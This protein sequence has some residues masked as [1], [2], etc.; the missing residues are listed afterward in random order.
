MRLPEVVHGCASCQLYYHPVIGCP[1]LS[2]GYQPLTI[3]SCSILPMRV[4]NSKFENALWSQDFPTL[5]K[6]PA[7]ELRPTRD[8]DQILINLETYVLLKFSFGT[9]SKI[10]AWLNENSRHLMVGA[11][12]DTQFKGFDNPEYIKGIAYNPQDKSSASGVVETAQWVQV[13]CEMDKPGRFYLR[14][15]GW[16]RLVAL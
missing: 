2:M 16:L 12:G 1:Q 4:Q 3:T 8:S 10:S 13:T 11:H 5:L 9:K 6:P 7:V 15:W 14:I